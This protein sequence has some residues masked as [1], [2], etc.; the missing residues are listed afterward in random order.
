M[1]KSPT[2]TPLASH[3][4]FGVQDVVATKDE[5]PPVR[6]QGMFRVQPPLST[7]PPK[8]VHVLLPSIPLR[9]LSWQ[10]RRFRAKRL[11]VKLSLPN[12]LCSLACFLRTHTRTQNDA[13]EGLSFGSSGGIGRFQVGHASKKTARSTT[14]PRIQR[15]VSWCFTGIISLRK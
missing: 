3:C 9:A 10:S 5:R 15:L 1:E 4:P 8:A 14:P 13:P 12:L 2:S 6:S 7:H 11:T